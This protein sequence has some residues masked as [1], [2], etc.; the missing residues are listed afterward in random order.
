MLGITILLTNSQTLFYW[1]LQFLIWLLLQV[2]FVASSLIPWNF[3]YLS[4]GSFQPFNTLLCLFSF[5]LWAVWH[6]LQSASFYRII[7]L[8]GTLEIIQ[9]KHFLWVLRKLRP[10]EVSGIKL[11]CLQFT[12]YT[13]L[14]DLPDRLKRLKQE[15][16]SV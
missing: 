1:L 14:E 10:W 7:K 4:L 13:S 16:F 3:P 15:G 9:C 6:S 12:H 8:E 11:L 5:L 2:L